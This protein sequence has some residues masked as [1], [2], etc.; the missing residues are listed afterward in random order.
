[1]L[2]KML[3]NFLLKMIEEAQ[4]SI[5]NHESNTLAV[6]LKKITSEQTTKY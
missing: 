5:E 3:Y 6:M 4:Y 2:E 1:M